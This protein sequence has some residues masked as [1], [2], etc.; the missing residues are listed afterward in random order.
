[1]SIN[2]KKLSR[3]EESYSLSKLIFD[4]FL[5]IV[6]AGGLALITWD[7]YSH[8]INVLKFMGLSVQVKI[9]TVIAIEILIARISCRIL[10]NRKTIIKY[11]TAI[12]T[13]LSLT[14]LAVLINSV[15]HYML[16]IN[17]FDRSILPPFW[18]YA[19]TDFTYYIGIG[20]LRY[21]GVFVSYFI[22][23]LIVENDIVY[24]ILSAYNAGLRW[25]LGKAYDYLS[26]EEQVRFD[27][28]DADLILY[29]LSEKTHNYNVRKT[30]CDDKTIYTVEPKNENDEKNGDKGGGKYDLCYRRYTRRI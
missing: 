7:N 10:R 27:P 13:G 16:D 2:T 6:A 12:I 29:L 5:G 1:M 20:V 23:W 19:G 18:W 15:W 22:I 3:H 17:A 21:P 14:G 11:C 4:I 8:R 30:V 28:V 25:A 24:T 26:D 9:I